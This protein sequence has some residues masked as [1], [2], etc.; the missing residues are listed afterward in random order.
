MVPDDLSV[1]QSHG[2]HTAL[3]QVKQY[4]DIG[5]ELC[6]R[7][8]L[9]DTVESSFH[10]ASFDAKGSSFLWSAIIFS[11][12]LLTVKDSTPRSNSIDL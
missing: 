7:Q 6:I 5:S 12:I 3:L 4:N 2:L 10:A 11:R 1:I 8:G 9:S